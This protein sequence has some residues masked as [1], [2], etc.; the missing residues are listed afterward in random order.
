NAGRSCPS[1]AALMTGMYHHKAGVGAM[2]NPM[3]TLTAYQGFLN[4]SCMTIA[5]ALRSNGYATYMSGKWHIGNN[6][7]H[8]PV[9]RGF[10]HSF[11]S[12]QGTNS[13]FYPN[14]NPQTDLETMAIDSTYFI[15]PLVGYYN[16]VAFTDQAVRYI[17]ESKTD[18]PFFL[19]LAYTS[20]HWPLQ[21]LPED[22]A[23]YKGVYDKGYETVREERYNRMIQMGLLK[24]DWK[25]SS[26]D[27][28]VPPWKSLC[29]EEKTYWSKVMEVYAATVDRMDQG[30]GKVIAE[31]ERTNQLDNTLIMFLSDNGG[32][33]EEPG[34]SLDYTKNLAEMGNA[35]SFI[36]YGSKWANTS[37][38][39]FKKFKHFE[40]EGGISTP[41]LARYPAI[42][43]AGT[44]TT[45]AAH[46]TDIMSTC[47][48][49]SNTQYPTS[50]NSKL[51]PLD[52]VSL[53][54]AFKG[55]NTVLN[56]TIFFEHLGF[57]ALRLGEYKI[58]SVYPEN[59]WSL[60]N[61]ASD[62]TET[63]NLSK[64]MPAKVTELDSIYQKIAKRSNVTD[65][66]IV[67]K[68]GSPGEMRRKAKNR[69][70]D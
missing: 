6:R 18:K 54:P 23:K 65:W 43:K 50:T 20:P 25:I 19:Y 46:I 14:G 35:K 17:S 63:T 12:K 69:D 52:G 22:I 7:P 45:Q 34:K 66:S 57:R 8:W 55:E 56:D 39:P 47:L 61:I 26:R 53:L 33:A 2:A 13:Y 64:A 42:I 67:S 9:D 48:D 49:V 40:H 32:C 5:E 62:R 24:P 68:L 38:V 41:F 31:L 15:A 10:E 58:V 16:T 60:Y 28:S 21:A 36:S 1:R 70:K 3:G 44:L 30:I 51:R 29:D 27:S 11:F 4:D 37:N 59:V